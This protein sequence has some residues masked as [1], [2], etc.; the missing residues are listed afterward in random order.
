MKNVTITLPDELATRTRVAAA[1]QN[2]SVSRY[3]AD[4]LAETCAR[5]EGTREEA[6]TT[7][8]AFLSSP[9]S[10]GISKLWKGRDTLYAEREDV[11]LRRYDASRLRDRSGESDKTATGRGFA[12]SDRKGRYT[13]P[14]RTK[15]K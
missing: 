1:R 3:I 8:E 5:D 10:P 14:K 6:V 4:L 2:K 12:G 11:L 9:G 15:P 13:G 7:L